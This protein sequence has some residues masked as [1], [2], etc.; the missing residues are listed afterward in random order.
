MEERKLKFNQ[1]SLALYVTIAVGMTLLIGVGWI[2]KSYLDGKT[3]F[4]NSTIKEKISNSHTYNIA[5]S[6]FL[7]PMG[8]NDDLF[9]EEKV[10]TKTPDDELE[11]E[12]AVFEEKIGNEE[13]EQ[14]YYPTNEQESTWNYQPTPEAS[15]NSYPSEKDND[16][17]SNSTDS[18]DEKTVQ[19][20]PENSSS[21]S[22]DKEE[23]DIP[24]ED[25]DDSTNPT[26][27]EPEESPNENPDNPENQENPEDP[28]QGTEDPQIP[29][30]QDPKKEPKNNKQTNH[31]KSNGSDQ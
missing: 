24:T 6:S 7:S 14:Y 8:I 15:Y 11:N 26:E 13:E 30:D 25:L 31:K 5:S 12:T 9:S 10:E 28:N 22:T 18:F 3:V 20:S 17:E 2:G 23:E 29:E 1:D 21:D 4:N 27:Q 16:P 19:S